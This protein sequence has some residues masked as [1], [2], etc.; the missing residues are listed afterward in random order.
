M[1]KWLVNLFAFFLLGIELVFRKALNVDSLE[2]MGPSLSV[3]GLAFLLPLIVPKKRQLDANVKQALTG[4]GLDP[5]TV[6]TTAEHRFINAVFIVIFVL[7]F[8]W[9]FPFIL[10]S[11]S[12]KAIGGYSHIPY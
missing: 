5:D 1:R 7:I 4:A 9:L 6:T 12:P 8:L 2:F 11:E 3:A 10:L